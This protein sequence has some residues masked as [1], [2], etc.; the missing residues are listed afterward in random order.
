MFSDILVKIDLYLLCIKRHLP[1]K[2]CN[3]LKQLLNHFTDEEA[4]IQKR[5]NLSKGTT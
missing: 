1:F 5:T 4:E 2:T 3:T